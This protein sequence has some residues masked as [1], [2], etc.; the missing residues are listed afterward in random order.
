MPGYATPGDIGSGGTGISGGVRAVKKQGW[1]PTPAPRPP[2]MPSYAP[3]VISNSSGN[4]VRPSPPPSSGPGPI[5]SISPPPRAP[6]APSI[7]AYLGMDT[8][9][10]QQVRDFQNALASYL[11]SEKT[12]KSKINE[13]YGSANK[14]LNTQKTQDLAGIQNDFASRGLL[15]SGLFADANSKYNTDFL[16]KLAELTKNQRRGLTDLSTGETDYRRQQTLETQRAREQAI[17]RRA[18][19]YGL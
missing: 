14:A 13:D 3:S 10:Q 18:S 2:A 8:T 1:K 5:P 16:S 19:K 4:Y 17:A 9:Y 12:Q 15:T 6:S 7:N 11:A